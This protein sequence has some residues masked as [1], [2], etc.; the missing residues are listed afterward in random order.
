MRSLVGII[1]GYLGDYMAGRLYGG[2]QWIIC[3]KQK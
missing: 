3:Q 1:M 2:I